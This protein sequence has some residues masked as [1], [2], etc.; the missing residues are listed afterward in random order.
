[1][2]K[3]INREAPLSGL[4]S[5]MAMK[6]RQGDTELIH[7]TKPEIAGL[8][9]LGKITINPDT[10]L[11][12][13]FSLKSLL[14]TLAALGITAATGGAG[15]PAL[16]AGSS[17]VLPAVAAGATSAIVNDGDLGA[18]AFDGLLAGAGGALG[19]T[20]AGA[21]EA[22][23]G[24][25]AV[26]GAT[27]AG[28]TGALPTAIAPAT[29]DLLTTTAA[30]LPPTTTLSG[31]PFVANNAITPA[32]IDAL[33]TS[34]G[35]EAIIKGAGEGS[36]TGKLLK[37]VGVENVTKPFDFA[38]GIPGLQSLTPLNTAAGAASTAATSGG[39][40]ALG[41]PSTGTGYK[42]SLEFKAPEIAA[43]DAA[44]SSYGTRAA[45][46]IRSQ[47]AP[48]GLTT[49]D[50]LNSSLGRTDPLRYFNAGSPSSTSAPSSLY[51]Q[52]SSVIA[53]PAEG[54]GPVG[55][56]VSQAAGG[57]SLQRIYEGMGG[58]IET[59]R[60]LV[61]GGGVGSDGMS[62]DISFEVIDDGEEGPD[63]ALLSKDEYV[64]DAHTVAALG[65]GST[66]SGAD[67]LDNFV[68]SIRNK[69]Y[70][71]GEQPK[72]LNGLRELASLLS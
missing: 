33:S 31:V 55:A 39:T 65:N 36:I 66:D 14:P 32:G 9:S 4:S 21:G 29:T 48:Q 42:E 63:G 61:E 51:G 46:A 50:V 40:A 24:L 11:P 56:Y 3:M 13:A 2:A 15:A 60:G 28:G 6:G 70:N 26:G 22:T 64:I 62:D 59:F 58:D 30:G 34:A 18:I 37:G 44:Q 10:G 35:K 45:D 52:Q 16:F 19:S 69:V 68:A 25:D 41:L 5:L 53:N 47:T 20:L 71:K 23:A 49:Q 12:E 72:E 43:R 27:A 7:M 1:M 8:A 57:G 17:F 38:K 67:V 54:P